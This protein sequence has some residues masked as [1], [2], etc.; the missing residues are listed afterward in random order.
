MRSS[1][2]WA[3]PKVTEVKVKGHLVKMLIL[4]LNSI[5]FLT[6]QE[7]YGSGSKVTFVRVKGHIC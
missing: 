2:T 3:R 5:D 6:G 4:G 1:V 7:S